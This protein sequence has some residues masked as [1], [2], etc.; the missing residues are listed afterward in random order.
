MSWTSVAPQPEVLTSHPSGTGEISHH[1]TN[2]HK[3]TCAKLSSGCMFT[4]CKKHKRVLSL[5]LDPT[6]Q[7]WYLFRHSKN[8]QKNKGSE[9]QS[10]SD[11]GQLTCSKCVEDKDDNKYFIF[12]NV[13]IRQDSEITQ[14]SINTEMVKLTYPVTTSYCTVLRT[15]SLEATQTAQPVRTSHISTT[16]AQNPSKK[17]GDCT[18]VGYRVCWPAEPSLTGMY[19]RLTSSLHMHTHTIHSLIKHILIF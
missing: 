7:I 4:L 14:K 18:Q 2:F 3:Q 1:E 17:P 8:P 13:A 19:P 15:S 11:E 9:L 10:F 6:L 16:D 5:E 12:N